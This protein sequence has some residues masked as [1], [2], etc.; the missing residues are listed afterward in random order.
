M[1]DLLNQ[2]H[3]LRKLEIVDGDILCFERKLANQE[4]YYI[5]SFLCLF[6]N[7]IYYFYYF[8]Y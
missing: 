2:N 6:F 4:E 7:Y 3:S 8:Y 1:I 5:I